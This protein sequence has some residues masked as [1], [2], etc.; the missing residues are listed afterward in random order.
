M[1]RPGER[2][3]TVGSV[4]PSLSMLSAEWS[5]MTPSRSYQGV[6]IPKADYP[7]PVTSRWTRGPGL[8]DTRHSG[9]TTRTQLA[10]PAFGPNKTETWRWTSHSPTV[11]SEGSSPNEVRI[12]S[13]VCPYLFFRANRSRWAP[14]PRLIQSRSQ[15]GFVRQ[16]CGSMMTD[17]AL[18]NAHVPKLPSGLI[19]TSG[20][21]A[22]SSPNGAGAQIPP[23][24]FRR[25][26]RP[27]RVV[28]TVSTA[29]ETGR[30]PQPL[31]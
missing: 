14:V 25:S 21:P 11:R 1:Q 15:A 31:S 10:F 9:Y 18:R 12:G 3:K 29:F 20:P 19:S 26:D 24:Q 23:L 6:I 13:L 17:A 5:E 4:A 28:R 27:G 16:T 7:V 22:S 30:I 8:L 2:Q